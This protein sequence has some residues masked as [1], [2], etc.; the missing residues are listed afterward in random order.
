MTYLRSDI[1]SAWADRDPIDTAFALRGEVFR[2][3]PGRKTQRVEIDG[4]AYFVKLH[5]GV[6]WGEVL[7]NWLQLKR[8]VIGAENEYVA[9]RDLLEEGIAAP[10]P[11]AF[12][13][14]S[15]SIATQRSF[16]LCDELKDF[17]SLE[18]ITNT[19]ATSPPSL[20]NKRAL[21]CAVAEFARA[22]HGQGFIHRDFYICHLLADDAALAGN[23]VKLAVLDLHRARRFAQ[24]PDRWLKRD[25]AA[26]LYSV[27]DL[28]VSQN[29]WLR[30][31]RIYCGRS[32]KEEWAAR[33]EFWREV[34]NRAQKLHS[35]GQRKGW[36]LSIF[37]QN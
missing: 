37:W 1:A 2:D 22:F 17:T 33:G 16:V 36:F 4:K 24:I 27:M 5:Y 31:V 29:D 14:T 21:L 3:V 35:K 32:L 6:G 25:L 20:S 7:K 12:A 28:D 8:P 30:F 10:K 11:A 18:D 15:G 26:L 13:K 9:C 19:W 34:F 23:V